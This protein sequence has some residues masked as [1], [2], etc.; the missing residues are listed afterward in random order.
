MLS[1]SASASTIAVSPTTPEASSSTPEAPT[2]GSTPGGTPR[3][4][5]KRARTPSRWKRSVTKRKR[6]N[7]FPLLLKNW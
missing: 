5:R 2:S 7:T 1:S 4:G 3:V 6:K